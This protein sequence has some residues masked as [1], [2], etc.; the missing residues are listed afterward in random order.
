[1]KIVTRHFSEER[2][3][4]LDSLLALGPIN[5]FS[6]W[7]E[8]P[9]HRD[10]LKGYALAKGVDITIVEKPGPITVTITFPELE[11][12]CDSTGDSP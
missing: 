7:V 8:N 10:F 5:L 2:N 9:V 12:H 6:F 1:M 4:T 3:T 11:L